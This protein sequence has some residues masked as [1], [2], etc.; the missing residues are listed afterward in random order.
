M[1]NRPRPYRSVDEFILEKMG[2]R[3]V[4]ELMPPPK[5]I[6]IP[7][8][9]MAVDIYSLDE[10]AD[11]ILHGVGSAGSQAPVEVWEEQGK[12]IIFNGAERWLEALV[13]RQKKVAA[14]ILGHG[15]IP[16]QPG[17]FFQADLDDPTFGLETVLP[18]DVVKRLFGGG[19]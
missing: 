10:A 14:I 11:S 12:F 3:L 6:D 17:I 8:T 2:E 1:R 15:L 4:G 18:L 7:L 9:D 16:F 5:I 13:E 19:M